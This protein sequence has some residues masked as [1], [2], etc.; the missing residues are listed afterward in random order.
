MKSPD[1]RSGSLFKT[2]LTLSEILESKEEILEKVCA[3]VRITT[4][5]HFR[6][7]RDPS[8]IKIY[9][10]GHLKT[11]HE[12]PPKLFIFCSHKI[13]RFEGHFFKMKIRFS[14]WREKCGYLKKEL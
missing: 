12:N 11:N 5:S 2:W 9:P 3:S 6:Y 8:L 10:T 7:Q 4:I 1:S 13:V 14:K